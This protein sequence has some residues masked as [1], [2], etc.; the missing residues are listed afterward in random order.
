VSHDKRPSCSVL[1]LV[2]GSSCNNMI[3]ICNK[4]EGDV[5]SVTDDFE[6]DVIGKN[7]TNTNIEFCSIFHLHTT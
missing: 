3:N 1:T 4:G 2:Q 5:D 7:I 6:I